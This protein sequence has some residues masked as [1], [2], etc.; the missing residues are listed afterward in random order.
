[1]KI[2]NMF[3]SLKTLCTPFL[4]VMQKPLPTTVRAEASLPAPQCV[5]VQLNWTPSCQARAA[6]AEGALGPCGLGTESLLRAGDGTA[7]RDV[8]HFHKVTPGYRTL[9]PPAWRNPSS[10][11]CEV[12]KGLCC[13]PLQLTGTPAACHQLTCKTQLL[14]WCTSCLTLHLLSFFMLCISF[15]SWIFPAY[16]SVK[17]NPKIPGHA[18]AC[19]SNHVFHWLSK[20]LWQWEL[21]RWS[22]KQVRTSELANVPSFGE[23]EKECVYTDKYHVHTEA[24]HASTAGGKQGKSDGK[25]RTRGMRG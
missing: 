22:K 10:L 1:M 13:T 9:H 12:L 17:S 7:R 15:S 16:L 19:A 23:G 20:V 25:G 6:A 3:E 5:C 8:L 18:E 14:K 11:K 2:F 24:S 21:D 4:P